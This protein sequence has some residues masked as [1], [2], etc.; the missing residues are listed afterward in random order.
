MRD[1]LAKFHAR[2]F[3]PDLMT[4][5]VVGDIV[6]AQAIDK[7]ARVLGDWK[8]IGVPPDH[9]IADAPKSQMVVRRDT[10]VPGKTQL[11]LV[12]GS[13]GV[14]RTE[15]DYEALNLGDLILGRLGLSGG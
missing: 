6:P 9:G 7:I 2:Y 15:P 14:R 4:L 5:A 3:H 13:V 11:D 1:A 8:A 12:L 10:L